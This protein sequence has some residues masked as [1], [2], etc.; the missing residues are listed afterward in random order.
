MLV[1]Y[2]FFIFDKKKMD[3]IQKIHIGSMIRD[4]IEKN[5]LSRT[6]I[7]LKMGLP[8]TVFY[9]Y[10]KRASLQASNL[11]RLC[12][13][14][15]YN[16]FMDI[17]NRLPESYVFDKTLRTSKDFIIAEQEAEITKLKLE[18]QLMKEILIKRG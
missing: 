8:N 7:A 18:N 1:R 9:A 4:Y 17:A 16:F 3:T 5:N 2:L 13:N 15:Q 10:E 14:F 12:E 11:L 6:R